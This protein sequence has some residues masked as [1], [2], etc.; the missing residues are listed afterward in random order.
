M[1]KK[2]IIKTIIIILIVLLI[3]FLIHTTRNVI[4]IS[5]LQKKVT[6][7]VN[8]N[9]Y[10]INMI[11]QLDNEITLNINYYKKGD[12][13]VIFLE[14]ENPNG[15]RIKVSTYDNGTSGIN[16]YTETANSKIASLNNSSELLGVQVVNFLQTDNIWQTIL[17][18]IPAKIKSEEYN[19]QTCYIVSNFLSSSYLMSQNKNEY[20]FDKETG[21][22]IKSIMDNDIS[23]REY[24]FNN[25]DDSIFIEPDINQYQVQESN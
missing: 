20:Y 19:N 18:S 7:Y 25:V 24:N 22:M 14:R 23:K 21:L 4:I 16:T 1:K 12:K 5:K 8:S 17:C 2:K 3:I 11:S 9:N 6:E 15:E 10:H 13:Q